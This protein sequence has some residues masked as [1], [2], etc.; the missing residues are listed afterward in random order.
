MSSGDSIAGACGPDVWGEK[1]AGDGGRRRPPDSR[2]LPAG[3]MELFHRRPVEP[4]DVERDVR[5]QILMLNPTTGELP[6][7]DEDDPAWQRYGLGP[8]LD[9]PRSLEESVR[10]QDRW[11]L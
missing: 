7:V 5:R 9:L 2:I 10:A 3:Q 6:S 11:I 1:H 8:V 4:E